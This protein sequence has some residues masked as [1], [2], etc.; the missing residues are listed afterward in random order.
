MNIWT[1]TL[2]NKLP[3]LVQTGRLR[4]ILP[5][6]SIIEAGDPGADAVC[7]RIHGETWLRRIVMDPD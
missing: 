3:G 7:I 2:R 6:L 1:R 5:D 4:V